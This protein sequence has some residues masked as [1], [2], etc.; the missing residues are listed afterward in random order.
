MERA[1]R[2]G[3]ITAAL[4]LTGTAGSFMTTMVIPLQPRLPALLDAHPSDT[5]WIVTV[6]LLVSAILTPIAGRLGD[7]YGK[8]NVLLALLGLVVVGSVVA[9]L[10][11]SLAPVLVGRALQGAGLA[12][13]P[14]GIGILRDVMS[15]P[16]LGAATGLVTASVGLG[17]SLAQPLSAYLAERVDWHAVFWVGAGLAVACGVIVVV[18]VPAHLSATG[19]RFD[20]VGA[21]GLAAGL[22]GIVIAIS[23]SNE[24]GWAGAGG[25]FAGGV[26]ILM[27]WGA[28]ELR[29]HEPLVDLRTTSLPPVL[30]TNLASIGV[31]FILFGGNIVFPRLLQQA[32]DDG[33]VGLT[34]FEASLVI[35][36]SGFAAVATSFLGG[37][38]LA[39]AS[40]ALILIAGALCVGAAYGV[41]MIVPA[42][43]VSIGLIN[44][45]AAVGGGL[46]FAAMPALINRSVPITQTGS[47]NGVNAL[48]RSLGTSSAAATLA[49][50]LALSTTT[51]AGGAVIAMDGFHAAFAI[52]IGVAVVVIIIATAIPRPKLPKSEQDIPSPDTIV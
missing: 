3:S 12:V 36:P 41:A 7:M 28:W 45:G 38:L 19:G 51:T 15:G 18:I 30:L 26:V 40:P 52:I 43:A 35:V 44:G 37:R 22:T 9:A 2:V 49:A 29:R 14:L 34:V 8:R 39:R 42:G 24:W 20:L 48:M 32:T 5:A 50:A 46:A 23:R 16:R 1:P 4:A 13:I 11:D 31:G 21:F 17:S 25:L 10:S 27:V 47:A 6:T 33:G